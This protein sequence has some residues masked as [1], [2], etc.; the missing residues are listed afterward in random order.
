MKS[1][2]E[3]EGT[4]LVDHKIPLWIIFLNS[5]EVSHKGNH[6]SFFCLPCIKTILQSLVYIHSVIKPYIKS[7]P[8]VYIVYLT[9]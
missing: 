5:N 7:P 1:T 3:G 8:L 6:L 4:F 9:W 2:E